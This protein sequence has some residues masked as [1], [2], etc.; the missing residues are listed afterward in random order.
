MPVPLHNFSDSF[1]LAQRD[2]ELKRQLVGY[3][4]TDALSPPD[5]SDLVSRTTDAMTWVIQK[6]RARYATDPARLVAV[7]SSSPEANALAVW[8]GSERDWIVISEGLMELLRSGVKDVAGRFNHAYPDLLRCELM[9]KLLEQAPLSGGFDSSLSSFMY[10]G[11]VAFFVG[12]EAGHHLAGHDGHY[13][14]GAHAERPADS[15]DTE[16]FGSEEWRIRHALERDADLIGLDF[17]RNAIE[18]LLSQLW[19]VRDF[20]PAERRDSQRVLAAL[21][22][23][24]V[25]T[26]TL[27][28]KPREI[29]WS[30]VPKQSHPPAVVRAVILSAALNRY[31]KRSFSDMG[32]NTRARIRLVSLELAAA[33]T[34]VPRSPADKV[35]QARLARGGEPA[36]IRATGIRKAL[37]DSQFDDYIAS[38]ESTM[39]AVR[40]RLKPRT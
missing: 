4:K 37:H 26:S 1:A 7:V 29:D 30:A 10:F 36:A 34:I 21:I 6:A 17:C 40:P 22:G 31:F 39:R 13:V 25:L 35:Y 3:L 8:S 28:I 18:T 38:L 24:G 9:Q 32:A 5:K 12:H 11:A 23:A 27:L 19:E 14:G 16:H 20:S 33:A 15:A 2:S